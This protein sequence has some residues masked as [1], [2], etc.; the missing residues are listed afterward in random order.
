MPQLI[1]FSYQQ[2]LD[3]QRSTYRPIA[4]RNAQDL[5]STANLA[6]SVTK[7]ASIQTYLTIRYLVDT[8]LVDDAYR[9][10]AYF[11]SLIHI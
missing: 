10:Y 5:S 2:S 11:L 4:G 6:A 8:Q 1:L 7:E 9:A 3:E